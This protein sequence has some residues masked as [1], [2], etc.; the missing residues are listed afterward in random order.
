M[1][2]GMNHVGIV[3]ADMDRSV[4]FYRDMLGMELLGQAFAFG[5]P[6]FDQVMA[7]DNVKGKICMM[8]KA[9]VQLELYEFETPAS[10]VKDPNYAVSDRG[11][12][13]FGVNVED[14]DATYERL[15]AAGVRFHCPVL[16]FG[17][18]MK[19]TYGRDPDGNVFELMELPRDPVGS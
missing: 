7:L 16:Q 9:N 18:G 11:I 14:I 4:S 12:S 13:H 10:A 17:S 8:K 15:S 19:A 1:I 3:V 5:G 6:L 2:T